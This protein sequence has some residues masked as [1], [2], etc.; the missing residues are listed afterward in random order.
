VTS[1]SKIAIQGAAGKVTTRTGA[2]A[3]QNLAV[4]LKKYSDWSQLSLMD[5]DSKSN[6]EQQTK[7]QY[8]KEQHLPFKPKHPRDVAFVFVRIGI[9]RTMSIIATASSRCGRH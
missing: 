9:A 6:I 3:A 1:S 2:M 5:D 8:Q 4:F 7:L